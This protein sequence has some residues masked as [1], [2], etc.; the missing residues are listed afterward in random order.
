[1]KQVLGNE[2]S[3]R[4]ITLKVVEALW[5]LTFV[6]NAGVVFKYYPAVSWSM[7]TSQRQSR[8]PFSLDPLERSLCPWNGLS[9]KLV[10]LVYSGLRLGGG[11]SWVKHEKCLEVWLIRVCCGDW[12]H[13]VNEL[14]RG[15]KRLL[16][17]LNGPCR[18]GVNFVTSVSRGC[19]LCYSTLTVSRGC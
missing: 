12:G 6:I 15:V 5:C 14:Q 9:G 13:V 16:A 19:K 18:D 2:F 3:V 4:W 8:T 10:A 17:L 1:M 7:L 11:V